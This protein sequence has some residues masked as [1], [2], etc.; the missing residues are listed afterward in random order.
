MA[1]GA[2]GLQLIAQGGLGHQDKD[3]D[4][5]DDRHH[6]AAVDL[7]AGE[8]LV[9]PQLGRLH[10][11]ERSLIDI[12]RLGVLHMVLEVGKQAAIVKQP[13]YQVGGDPVGH[14]TG[15]HLIDVEEG[16][17]QAGDTTP[18]GASQ[19]S[20]HKSDHPHQGSRHHAGGDR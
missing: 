4:G 2:T 16:L 12:G 6:N 7:G 19:A 5:N 13:G 8:D 14:D 10:T 20:A 17:D 1:V 9:Q 11:V 18:D 15:Q 3:Q